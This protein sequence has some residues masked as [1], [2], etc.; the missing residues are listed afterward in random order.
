MHNSLIFRIFVLPKERPNM[1][2]QTDLCQLLA[3]AQQSIEDIGA[4][5]RR[6]QELT[7]ELRPMLIDALDHYFMNLEHEV[8]L[9]PALNVAIKESNLGEEPGTLIEYA[10][11][12]SVKFND[13]NGLTVVAI[14][15]VAD[16][17][18]NPAYDY[19]LENLDCYDL[20]ALLNA[21]LKK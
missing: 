21:L 8:A 1:K 19:S 20:T 15:G 2:Q 6:A 11:I 14:D 7:E 3:Q 13:D 4:A 10:D 12:A 5:R 9:T 18:G 16:E 17:D